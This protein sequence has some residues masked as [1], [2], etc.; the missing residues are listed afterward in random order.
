MKHIE[1]RYFHILQEVMLSDDMVVIETN[2]AEAFELGR[3][4]AMQGIPPDEVAHIHH[5]V[6][7]RL[8]QKLPD[9]TFSRVSERL[10]KSLIELSM[11]YGLAFR[12]QTER[13]YQDMVNA[14]LEQSHKLEAIGTLAAGIAHDFNNIL[15]SIIGFSEMAA[16]ELPETSSERYCISQVLIASFRGRDLVGRLLNFARQI[17]AEPMLVEMVAEIREALALLNASCKQTM[18]IKFHTSIEE[19]MVLAGKGQLQQIM[20]NLCINAVDAMN[21]QGEIVVTMEPVMLDDAIYTSGKAGICLIVV[22]RGHGMSPKV[23]EQI[24]DPFFT[25]KGPETGNG[26]GLSVVHSIVSQL[27]GSIEVKSQMDGINKGTEF[28][29]LLPLVESE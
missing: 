9:L 10:G 18:K 6:S 14:R 28:K 22:D 3:S 26:L 23:Q 8:A 12:E 2:L 5:K 7:V 25:T 1:K 16:D 17:P 24:F 13:R 21:H 29:V 19:A 20:M 15:G 4:M 27:G 11:A